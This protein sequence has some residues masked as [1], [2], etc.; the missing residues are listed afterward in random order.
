MNP[1]EE[2]L[3]KLETR[4]VRYRNFNILLCL[5]LVAMI[6]VASTEGISPFRIG[7]FLAPMATSKADFEIPDA[8][9]EGIV[10]YKAS[11]RAEI[12]KSSGTDARCD[13][14]EGIADCEQ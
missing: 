12:R 7:S 13:S 11:G 4:V 10:R 9:T 14:H 8:P 1:L 3:C 2:R 5:L 6:T